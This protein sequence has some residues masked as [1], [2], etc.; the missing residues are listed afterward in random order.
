MAG[1]SRR[2]GKG[3]RKAVQ[4]LPERKGNFRFERIVVDWRSGFVLD[5][6]RKE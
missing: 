3:P 1:C 5:L 2:A 6:R 4:S